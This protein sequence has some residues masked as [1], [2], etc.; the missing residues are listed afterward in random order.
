M[1][2]KNKNVD[3]DAQIGDAK[4]SIEKNA[5][6]TNIDIDTKKVD[7]TINKTADKSTFNLDTEKLDVTVEKTGED[8]VINVSAKNKFLKWIGKIIGKVVAKRKKK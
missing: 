3:I 5:D 6:K 2:K 8:T 4:I 1:A 7:V